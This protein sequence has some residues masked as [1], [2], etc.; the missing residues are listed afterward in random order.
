MT[1]EAMQIDLTHAF[2]RIVDTWYG[3]FNGEVAEHM[4]AMACAYPGNFDAGMIDHV[5]NEATHTHQHLRWNQ[6]A[7]ATDSNWELRR[8]FSSIS[9]DLRVVWDALEF[10]NDGTQYYLIDNAQAYVELT[11]PSQSLSL[12]V[13]G[14]FGHPHFYGHVARL[15]VWFQIVVHDGTTTIRNEHRG[16]EICGDGTR[17]VLPV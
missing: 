13:Q 9:W 3:L 10:T 1:T 5:N 6:T 4:P 11:D 15:P 7:K 8:L 17:E 12:N 16:F 14:S 2:N